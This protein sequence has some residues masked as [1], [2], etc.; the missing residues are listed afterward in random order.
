M[1]IYT[2]IY[3]HIS[4]EERDSKGEPAVGGTR[5]EGERMAVEMQHIVSE[6]LINGYGEETSRLAP[7]ISRSP[8]SV[9][10]AFLFGELALQ[11][12]HS[13]FDSH[14]GDDISS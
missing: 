1:F 14:D 12:S 2:Y 3:V 9:I 8:T 7:D 10:F 5:G 4:F 13:K 11:Y 6:K